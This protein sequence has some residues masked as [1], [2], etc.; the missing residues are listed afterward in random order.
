MT[1]LWTL[2]DIMKDFFYEFLDIYI[3]GKVDFQICSKRDT[4]GIWPFS[5][6]KTFL[7]ELRVFFDNTIFERKMLEQKM[8]ESLKPRIIFDSH[9]FAKD[10][11]HERC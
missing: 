6:K 4:N 3:R 8:F 5:H 1:N 2:L 9:C 7:L 10:V 11:R